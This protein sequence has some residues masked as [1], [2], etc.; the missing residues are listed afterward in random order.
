M[1]SPASTVLRRSAIR[2]QPSGVAAET[3]EVRVSIFFHGQKFQPM[4]CCSYS[5]IAA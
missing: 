3:G 5:R 1:P 4:S 2:S